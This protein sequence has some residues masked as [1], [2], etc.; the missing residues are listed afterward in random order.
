MSSDPKLIP[1]VLP[2]IDGC[3]I[4]DVACG[5]G[6]WGYL[7][8][9]DFWYTA[10]GRPLKKQQLK[11][12]VGVDVF[13]PYLKFVKKHNVYDDVVLCDALH[14]PF[15]ARTFEVALATEVLEHLKKEQ[16]KALLK[17][18]ERVSR[19]STIITTPHNPTNIFC[20]QDV[21]DENIFQ[22]HVSKWNAKELKALGYAVIGRSFPFEGLLDIASFLFPRLTAIFP[23]VPFC[24]I[25]K[26]RLDTEVSAQQAK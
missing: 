24:L 17:E 22:K 3:K 11:F 1:Y 21:K 16:G 6:K 19:K 9:V 12:L 7:I 13:L 4:L 26:K 5:K 15:R 10:A 23:Q 14:L 2:L 25:A 8:K 18:I 20:H